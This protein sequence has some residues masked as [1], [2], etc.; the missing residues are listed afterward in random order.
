[1][2]S[3][4]PGSHLKR[5]LTDTLEEQKSVSVF[6]LEVVAY[7]FY[8]VSTAAGASKLTRDKLHDRKQAKRRLARFLSPAV[9]FAFFF[10]FKKMVVC[11]IVFRDTV[12]GQKIP[13]QYP[14]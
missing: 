5:Q 12:H 4:T 7:G 2:F 14:L 9:L 6:K 10:F 1:M 11:F 3:Y 8:P 13:E